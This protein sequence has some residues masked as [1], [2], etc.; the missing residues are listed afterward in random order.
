VI[1]FNGLFKMKVLIAYDT[2]S[3]SKMTAKIA[4]TIGASLKEKGLEVDTLF[5]NNVDKS[6]LKNYDLL[7]FG[8]PTMA[9]RVSTNMREFIESLKT[10][11]VSGK[12]AATF[13][14]QVQSRIS[15]NAAKA[16]DGKLKGLGC[17]MITTPLT[18]FVEGK[19]RE[20]EWHPKEG[21][22]EKTEHW[23]RNVAQILSQ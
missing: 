16:L 12:P 14:T 4:E 20:N 22:I 17:K 5:V 18:A 21:E 10:E 9:F 11:D 6:T 15:G 23:A 7:V 13:D 1:G 2:V 19:M 3:P 8:A